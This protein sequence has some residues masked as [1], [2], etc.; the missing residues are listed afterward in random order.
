MKKAV[1]TLICSLAF[2]AGVM[3]QDAPLD[4]SKRVADYLLS[5][6]NHNVSKAQDGHTHIDSYYQEWRYVNG[7]LGVAVLN[8][9]DATGEKKFEQFVK[10]NF[11]FYFEP[12]IQRQLRKEYES[13]V[14]DNAWRRFFSMSSLDD[15]GAMGAALSELA[16]RYKD[17]R[18]E[19]YLDKISH[20]ILTQQ[21]R[22]PE[23][24][25]YCREGWESELSGSTTCICVLLSWLIREVARVHRPTCCRERQNRYCSSTVCSSTTTSTSIG[26][27][28]IMTR[29]MPTAPPTGEEPTDGHFWHRLS[30]STDCPK[31]I[32]CETDCCSCSEKEWKTSSP[33]RTHRACGTS[34]S[35]SLT[36]IPKLPAQPCLS[37]P[38]RMV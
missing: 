2:A 17:Q 37:Q 34:C 27:V 30:C 26:I 5:H 29:P 36:L 28:S 10:E 12:K 25:I 22:I 38:L 33:I 35:T 18:Y 20:Y 3:A 21:E 8:L 1:F 4:V 19:N 15:C 9:A 23:T 14:R 13:G 16:R 24:G 32:L 7:V 11:D 31:S 6:H